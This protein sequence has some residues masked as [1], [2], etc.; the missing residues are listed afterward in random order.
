MADVVERVKALIARTSS[1]HEEEARTA[2]VIACR[3][4]REHQL[5]VTTRGPTPSLGREDFWE[6]SERERRARAA[7]PRR[8]AEER[9]RQAAFDEWEERQRRERRE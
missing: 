7:D 3:L 2:A 4:I 5:E 8:A 9:A 1:P 6:R